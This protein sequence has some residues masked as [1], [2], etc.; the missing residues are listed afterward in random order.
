LREALERIFRKHS[1]QSTA[2]VLGPLALGLARSLIESAEP[3]RARLLTGREPLGYRLAG[4]V[5]ALP[6]GLSA[7]EINSS[8]ELEAVESRGAAVCE[9]NDRAG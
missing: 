2:A 3:A 6:T 9:G 1:G 8:A 5:D 7:V 4:G